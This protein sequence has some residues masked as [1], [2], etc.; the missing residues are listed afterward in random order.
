[1]PCG[2][3]SSYD[4]WARAGRNDGVVDAEEN[5]LGT[6]ADAAAFWEAQNGAISARRDAYLEAGWGE[7]VIVPPDAYWQ[8]W[9][10]EK[11]PKRKGGK[12]YIAVSA[13]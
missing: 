2:C 1:M 6:S 11:T 7:V 5:V 12:V 8:S 13:R 9:E 10:H 3:H 4:A